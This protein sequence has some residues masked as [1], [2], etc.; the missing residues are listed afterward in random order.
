MTEDYSQSLDY[1]TKYGAF[2]IVDDYQEEIDY[3]KAQ[4]Y[5][6]PIKVELLDK[7]K[8][9]PEV[10]RYLNN[11]TIMCFYENGDG[12]YCVSLIIK[13]GK[14][15]RPCHSH[16]FIDLIFNP[17]ALIRNRIK[18]TEYD[19]F[20]YDIYDDLMYQHYNDATFDEARIDRELLLAYIKTTGWNEI[21]AEDMSII[22][23]KL[24]EYY[25]LQV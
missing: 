10:I 2:D 25:T 20:Q 3:V 12:T 14:P 24:F 4:N 18:L 9:K 21:S 5:W 22:F 13:D 15:Q 23:T 19:G 17:N 6:K 16:N 8:D 7:F 11:L 1:W